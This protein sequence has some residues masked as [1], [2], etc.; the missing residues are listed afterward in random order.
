MKDFWCRF[1][2]VVHQNHGG[3]HTKFS[4]H[5]QKDREKWSHK[6]ILNS[7]IR[8]LTEKKLHAYSQKPWAKQDS[9]NKKKVPQKNIN[10]KPRKKKRNICEAL[11]CSNRVEQFLWRLHVFMLCS[12][13]CTNNLSMAPRNRNEKYYKDN[14]HKNCIKMFSNYFHD[15][16]QGCL[17]NI[18][19]KKASKI[20]C[21]FLHFCQLATRKRID[22]SVWMCQL[23]LRIIYDDEAEES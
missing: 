3:A 5:I 22:K 1:I 18:K 12:I 15:N 23:C 14:R 19:Q 16:F 13:Y 7:L 2:I 6:I 11:R 4:H 21:S 10:N 20:L 17:N 8:K 9:I